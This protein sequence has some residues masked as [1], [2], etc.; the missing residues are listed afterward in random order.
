[1]IQQDIVDRSQHSIAG[2]GRTGNGI[3]TLAVYQRT[4]LADELAVEGFFLRLGAVA[5]GLGKVLVAD[6]DLGDHAVVI[7]LQFHIHIAGKALAG[8]VVAVAAHFVDGHSRLDAE[9]RQRADG[10][11]RFVDAADNRAGRDGRS[12]D[13]VDFALI[14]GQVDRQLLAGKLAVEGFFLGLGA[15]AGGLFEVGAAHVDAV[16]QA[17]VVRG[18]GNFHRAGETGHGDSLDIADFLAVFVHAN[19]HGVKLAGSDMTALA[20]KLR[21]KGSV[22]L[23]LEAKAG[24]LGKISVLADLCFGDYA[25]F[26]RGDVHLNRAGKAARLGRGSACLAAELVIRLVESVHDRSGRD[27]S[28]ADC[29][30]AFH[31][32]EGFGFGQQILAHGHGLFRFNG[33]NAVLRAVMGEGQRQGGHHRDDRQHDPCGQCFLH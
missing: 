12:G 28:A 7:Q 16:E 1:M 30:D 2:D 15:K 14:L 26:I 11:A 32:I 18:H 13:S 21:G 20:D 31:L 22:F 19:I 5:G 3:H 4:G 8:G 23:G 29:I 27:G 25:V 6:D 9:A 10:G 33:G 24:G 17:L